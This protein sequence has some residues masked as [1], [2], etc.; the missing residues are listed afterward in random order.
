MWWA[1]S[2]LLQEAFGTVCSPLE[3]EVGGEVEGSELEGSHWVMCACSGSRGVVE[4][5]VDS[6][7]GVLCCLRH[8][9]LGW[10]HSLG[11]VTIRAKYSKTYDLQITTLQVRVRTCQD[12]REH[13]APCV[14][15]VHRF[16][17]EESLSLTKIPSCVLP[18]MACGS[19]GGFAVLG[20]PAV[21]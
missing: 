15:R 5:L 18:P 21:M 13:I 10:A 1:A 4:W 11:N 3:E 14:P 19:W 8:R 6:L 9:R 16:F 12:L 2:C 20:V 7:V 17:R